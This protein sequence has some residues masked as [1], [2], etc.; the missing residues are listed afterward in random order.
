MGSATTKLFSW[1]IVKSLHLLA[2]IGAMEAGF[3]VTFA[4]FIKDLLDSE[5]ISSP[6]HL[7]SLFVLLV[8]A[9]L[10]AGL[11][12]WERIEAER[13]GQDF[14]HNI[15]IKLFDHL[16]RL[17]FRVLSKK[18]KGP[19]LLRFM[20][21]LTAI[22]QWISLGVARLMVSSIIFFSAIT[23]LFIINEKIG[24][25]LG[26]LFFIAAIL[27][28][29]LGKYINNSVRNARKRRSILASG[30]TEK[31]MT[32]PIIQLLARRQVERRDFL[33]KSKRLKTAM[34]ERAN[35]I[36]LLRG[37]SRLTGSLA[38]VLAAFIG[39]QSLV[40]AQIGFGE[41][42][43]IIALVSFM[44]PAIYE[45]GRVYEYWH[46][47]KIA[48]EKLDNLLNLAPLIMPPPK[49]QRAKI[50]KFDIKFVNIIFPPALNNINA[51]AKYG[52]KIALTGAN[53]AGKSTLLHLLMR[54][55][56]AQS[57]DIFIGNKTIEKYG[58]G[59]LRRT[60]TLA[61][62][63]DPLFKGSVEKNIFYPNNGQRIDGADILLKKLGMDI[64][65]KRSV[66]YKKRLI[67]EGG[68]NLS[69]GEISAIVIARALLMQPKI[70]LLDEVDVHL[71]KNMKANLYNVLADM[72]STLI[73]ASHNPAIIGICDKVWEIDK[74][75]ISEFSPNQY[76]A[77]FH[78]LT[79]K[80]SIG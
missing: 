46:G 64:D 41:L 38:L 62:A 49:G 16:S 39:G 59:N 65:D 63:D 8:L 11:K 48:R 28:F 75:K 17:S 45:L 30:I 53:G 36:G 9:I 12:W 24:I 56:E 42:F 31:I 40:T 51:S 2:L 71:D 73:I 25:W 69:K 21:D 55:D 18:R 68:K 72:K 70:L 78:K 29:L 44:T 22:R 67:R 79:V 14:V 15:R 6:Q 60:I 32:M 77:S 27:A 61:S 33:R 52:E 3:S 5:K 23:A 66:F 74:G 50:R 80:K 13:I 47:A 57:G 26:G 37:L 7:T 4:F 1:Q 58:I 54:V 20:N 34:R 35:F 10:I 43:A 76:K 19:I